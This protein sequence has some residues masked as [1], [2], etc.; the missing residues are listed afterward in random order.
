M[1]FYI[2]L[3]KIDIFKIFLIFII[4]EKTRYEK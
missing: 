4:K 3:F 1:F 2:F